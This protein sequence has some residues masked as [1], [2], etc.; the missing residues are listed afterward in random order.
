MSLRG[1][2]R[3]LVLSQTKQNFFI[4]QFSPEQ[5]SYTCT[6]PNCTFQAQ[7][8]P[9]SLNFSIV[10]P[11]SCVT[12][13]FIP[14]N[15]PC[16]QIGSQICLSFSYDEIFAITLEPAKTFSNRYGT[17]AHDDVL[18]LPL[19]SKI[20]SVAKTSFG[21]SLAMTPDLFARTLQRSTQII[22]APDAAF[23]LQF[24]TP[25]MTIAEA[26]VGSGALSL[27][28]FESIEKRGKLFGYDVD[29]LRVQTANSNF[30]EWKIKNNMN[31]E[32]V[33]QTHDVAN[34]FLGVVDKSLD[35]VFLDLPEP[36]KVVSALQNSLKS[37]ALFVIFLPCIEQIHTFLGA[38]RD[39]IQ[40]KTIKI[41]ASGMELEQRCLPAS[42]VR[43][44]FKG[45]R[46]GEKFEFLKE[47]QMMRT[48]TG[49]MVL[50]RIQ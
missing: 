37:N 13:K 50:C 3:N 4:Q 8:G 38:S 18:A 14:V 5:I 24:V 35:F 20:F 41:N 32:F 49:Y 33:I 11:H 19:G 26:G 9:N 15:A 27:R 1:A 44:S 39:V 16:P 43:R 23:V 12:Q 6:A 34:G 22:F 17:F 29:D 28:L 36:F 30:Q 46:D 21:F 45:S 47:T 40:V 25:G 48:H 10:E 31:S 2:Y 7:I 42:G